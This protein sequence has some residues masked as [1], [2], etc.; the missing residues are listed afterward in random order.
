MSAAAVAAAGGAER[1]IFVVDLSSELA[2]AGTNKALKTK[3]S[4]MQTLKDGMQMFAFSKAWMRPQVPHH[5]HRTSF[6]TTSPL[7]PAWQA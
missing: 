6:F 3:C 2:A 7:V 1:V 5:G 4:K